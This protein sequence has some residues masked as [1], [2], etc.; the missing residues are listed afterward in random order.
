M[1][2]VCCKEFTGWVKSFTKLERSLTVLEAL[3]LVVLVALLILLI[4]HLVVCSKPDYRVDDIQTTKDITYGTKNGDRSTSVI[5]ISETRH[6]RFHT[7]SINNNKTFVSVSVSSN[8]EATVKCS[9]TPSD[10]TTA[11][12]YYYENGSIHDIHKVVTSTQHSRTLPATDHD[13]TGIVHPEYTATDT[14][15]EEIEQL[16]ID[17][18]SDGEEAKQEYK[19]H[20]VALIKLQPPKDAIFGCILTIVSDYWT[21]T[22]ASCIEAIEETDSLDSFVMME[23]YGNN[24]RESLVAVNDVQI[25]PLYEGK[26]KSYDLAMLRSGTSLTRAN[27]APVELASLLDYALLT[28]AQRFIILGYGPFR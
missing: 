25:H 20:M 5:S 24:M 7:T 12:V 6:P 3:L 11:A 8:E 13:I 14:S 22:A 17:E 1:S 18:Q 19:A 27:G 21:L 9:W 26:N 15:L 23:N 2:N 28:L 10:K 16:I 4:L